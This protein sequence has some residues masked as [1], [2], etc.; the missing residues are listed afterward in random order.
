MDGPRDYH[1]EWSKSERGREISYDIPYMWNPKQRYKWTYLQSRN[2]VKGIENRVKGIES[3]V[4]GI[5]NTLKV[6]KDN[7]GEG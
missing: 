5:E 3:R 6:T 1:I 2:R 4:K 7:G